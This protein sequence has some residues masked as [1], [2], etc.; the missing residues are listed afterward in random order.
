[1]TYDNVKFYDVELFLT[2]KP[3]SAYLRNL[4]KIT[5]FNSF[6]FPN[7]LLTNLTDGEVI[8]IKGLC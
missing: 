1:M 4:L 8:E 5:K 7:Q 6:H 3:M 2:S